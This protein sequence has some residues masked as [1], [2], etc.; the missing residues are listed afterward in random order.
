MM[1]WPGSGALATFRLGWHT[2]YMATRTEAITTPAGPGIL[3]GQVGELAPQPARRIHQQ[4]A[5]LDGLR[6]LAILLVAWCHT[7]FFLSSN[8]HVWHVEHVFGGAAWSGVILFFTLSGFLLFLPFARAI[9]AGE[10]W[11]STIHF[12]LRRALRILPAYYMLVPALLLVPVIF[13]YGLALDRFDPIHA[14]L[15]LTLLYDVPGGA[16]EVIKRFDSPLWSLTLEWQFYIILPLLALALA[17]IARRFRASTRQYDVWPWVLIVGLGLLA[18]IGIAVRAFAATAHYTWGYP[19]P[20]AM[21][22]HALLGVLI[23]IFYG[24]SGKYIE[25]FAL[26]M[27]ASVFYVAGVERNLLPERMRAPIGWLLCGVSLF[28]IA[29]CIPWELRANR[30][31]GLIGW[32]NNFPPTSSWLWGILGDETLAVCYTCLLLGVLLV[33]PLQRIFSWMPLRF[34][35]HISYSLYLWHIIGLELFFH[36]VRRSFHPYEVVLLWAVILLWSIA[37]YALV[38]RPFQRLQRR[39]RS[40]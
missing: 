21:S 2:R 31:F 5:S 35:G 39:L 13:K 11:P 19:D 30:L 38:E 34:L 18:A 29:A 17:W 7:D 8:T 6:G 20:A 16:Y 36:A 26:G 22:S 28:G 23:T 14:L 33:S 25:V 24:T 27:L 32:S 3:S 37:S 1:Q 15:G 40:T 4:F 10:R 12:Y 9:I